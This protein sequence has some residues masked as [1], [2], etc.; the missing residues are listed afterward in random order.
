MGVSSDWRDTEKI[1]ENNNEKVILSCLLDYSGGVVGYD[2]K[3]DFM[4]ARFKTTAMTFCDNAN[5]SRLGVVSIS[6]KEDTTTHITNVQ[7]VQANVKCSIQC[8]HNQ[9]MYVFNDGDGS[10]RIR[11][12]AM[13][14]QF[15]PLVQH[16]KARD[17]RNAV[18][19][20]NL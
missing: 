7:M 9:K 17:M 20:Q 6:N 5:K 15:K 3:Y 12:C 2:T 1:L 13:E 14:N 18:I 11:P 8:T 10:F 16:D 4:S 19:N